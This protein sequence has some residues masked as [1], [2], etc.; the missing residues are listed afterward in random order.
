MVSTETA[1]S[2]S[3]FALHTFYQITRPRLNSSTISGFENV[4]LEISIPE[5]PKEGSVMT[6]AL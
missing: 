2:A 1:F 4:T 6:S 5:H 3:Y